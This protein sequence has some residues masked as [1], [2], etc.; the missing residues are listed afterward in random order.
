MIQNLFKKGIKAQDG[1]YNNLRDSKKNW[2]IEAKEFCEQL[3]RKFQPYADKHFL[4]EIQRDFRSRF[5][6]MYLACSLMEMGAKISCPKTGPDIKID[7]IIGTIWIEAIAPGAGAPNSQDRVM[8]YKDLQDHSVPEKPIILR[9]ANAI[10]EKYRIKYFKYLNKG[11]VKEGDSYVIAL[12][13]SKIPS[14]GTDFNPPRIVRSVLPIGFPKVTFDKKS[15]SITKHTYDYRDRISKNSG[16]DVYT[17]IFFDDFYNNLSAILFSNVN[18]VNRSKLY[19]QDYILVHN[20]RAKNPLQGGI[21]KKG[22]EYRVK[23]FSDK[24]EVLSNHLT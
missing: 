14:S 20:P 19:G 10:Y 17:G 4:A 16:S 1:E 7:T 24:F 8:S 2:M 22:A 15:G 3:W 18:P 12:N 6:E 9:Y 21:I 13:G 11:I 5:W 23:E